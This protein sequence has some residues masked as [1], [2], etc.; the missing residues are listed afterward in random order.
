ML[1][2]ITLPCFSHLSSVLHYFVNIP[3]LFLKKVVP[4]WN[5]CSNLQYLPY[6]NLPLF[7][8]TLAILC[9]KIYMKLIYS[10]FGSQNILWLVKMERRG[11][12]YNKLEE[13][14]KCQKYP[15]PP[16]S[17][18][19]QNSSTLLTLDVQFQTNLLSLS[20]W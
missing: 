20:K 13:A 6:F 4:L 17:N 8:T 2:S 12:R 3:P 7:I 15:P 16:L 1:K 19:V 5:A 9:N 14:V 10:K 18:Y 11:T